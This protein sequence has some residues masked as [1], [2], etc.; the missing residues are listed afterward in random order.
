M[1]N[2]MSFLFSVVSVHAVNYVKLFR[3]TVPTE[4]LPWTDC[5]VFYGL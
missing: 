2:Q 1:H 4:A 5:Y 3:D